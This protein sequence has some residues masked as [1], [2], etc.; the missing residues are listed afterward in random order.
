M[1][2]AAGALCHLQERTPEAPGGHECKGGCGGQLHDECGE[3]EEQEENGNSELRR[4]CFACIG[5][6]SNAGAGKRKGEA[7][8]EEG[9]GDVSASPKRAKGQ[10]D[11]SAS[12]KRLTLDEKLEILALLDQG[13]IT[14]G[15]ISNRYGCKPRTV[16][17]I[18]AERKKLEEQVGK[19]RKPRRARKGST[20]SNR[21]EDNPEVR[22]AIVYTS[23]IWR[24]R[25]RRPAMETP[26]S[27]WYQYEYTGSRPGCPWPQCIHLKPV[28]RADMMGGF[29]GELFEGEYFVLQQ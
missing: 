26:P 20:K 6:A 9:C 27:T 12:R 24:G 7:D 10:G 22:L 1:P 28:R 5:G 17:L 18:K 23:G 19:E 14:H 11:K 8:T 29:V 4:I 13:A 2:C 15:E 16:R 3:M 21:P 25:R